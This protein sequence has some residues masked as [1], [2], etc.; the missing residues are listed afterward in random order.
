MTGRSRFRIIPLPN[1]QV[2]LPYFVLR[3]HHKTHCPY[4]QH[5]LG[6][7][8]NQECNTSF[9]FLSTLAQS[10]H[11]PARI[12]PGSVG[13][14]LLNTPKMVISKTTWYHSVDG[15]KNRKD[16]LPFCLLRSASGHG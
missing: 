7:Y 2:L 6:R 3:N 10:Y 14:G 13:G 1:F 16:R 9:D 8:N 12:P 11:P 5:A 4:C 15:V